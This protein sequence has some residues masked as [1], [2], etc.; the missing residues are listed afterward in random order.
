MSMIEISGMKE[1][2]WEMLVVK[3]VT[4]ETLVIYF[5]VTYNKF[6]RSVTLINIVQFFSPCYNIR[7]LI[8][9]FSVERITSVF[10]STWLLG[11][12]ARMR[13]SFPPFRVL[14]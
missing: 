1:I 5:K 8:K 13:T 2:I 10:K 9:F 3:G 14:I 11:W 12:E 4:V 6:T 7:K